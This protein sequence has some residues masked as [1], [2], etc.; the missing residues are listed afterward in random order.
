MLSSFILSAAMMGGTCSG[1][2]CQV[3][4]YA[5]TVPG[6]TCVPPAAVVTR[7]RTVIRSVA[8]APARAVA[9]RRPVRSVLFRGRCA[10]GLCG[11]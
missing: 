3:Q 9:A 1:P 10:G 7:Q 4:Q 2:N 8:V 6:P 5:I 11:R